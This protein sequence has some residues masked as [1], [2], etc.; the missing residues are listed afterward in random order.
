L[1]AD[2]T[3]PDTLNRHKYVYFHQETPAAFDE[4]LDAHQ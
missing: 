4:L 3:L 1:L 2:C